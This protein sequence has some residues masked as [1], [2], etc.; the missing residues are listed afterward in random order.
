MERGYN[1]VCINK[2]E[3]R[4]MVIPL[5]KAVGMLLRSEI[6]LDFHIE[7]LKAQAVAIRTNLLRTSKKVEINKFHL[8]SWDKDEYSEKVEKAVEE[9]KGIVITYNGKLIDAKY[10]AVCGGST[11]N[12][13]NVLKNPVSYLR[14][15]LCDYCKYSPYWQREKCFT[16]EEIEKLLKVKFPSMGV[17][18]SSEIEGF[19]QNIEKDEHGRVKSIKIGS[20]KFTGVE[21]MELLS[22]DST[23]F[24]IFPSEI[25][26]VSRGKGHGIGLC[27]YGAN[28]MG[29]EGYSFREILNYYYTGVEIENLI[30]PDVDKPLFGRKIM[31]DPGHG[32]EDIGYKGDYLGLLEKDIN[33]NLSLKLKEKLENLGADVYMTRER[34]ENIITVNRLEKANR[35]KPDFFI[36]IHMDYFPRSSMKGVEM[37]HFRDDD[38][39]KALGLCIYEKLKRE[40]VPVKSVK[41]G[42]FYIFRG[43][44]V[45]SLMIEAGYLSNKDE[46]IKFKD[47]EYVEKIIKGIANGILDYYEGLFNN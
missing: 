16:V 6:N 3:N 17:E 35:I 18:E 29:E 26:F 2:E 39:S 5:E 31:L 27:Q 15:V 47:G 34:D 22:L 24:S 4:E 28:R 19:I 42:N 44:S 10:H 1:I 7:A 25:K 21:L 8:S 38:E 40:Q 33:L 9:T 46:E 14:R 11:E 23:R 45:S 20:K 37:F 43:V 41:E 12:S 13:E 30:L 36:S 32:G